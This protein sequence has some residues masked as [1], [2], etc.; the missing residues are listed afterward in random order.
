MINNLISF[1]EIY[2]GTKKE[3]DLYYINADRG[4]LFTFNACVYA[5]RRSFGYDLAIA[6]NDLTESVLFSYEVPGGNF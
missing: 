5:C 1:P 6:K 3:D 2:F 4:S